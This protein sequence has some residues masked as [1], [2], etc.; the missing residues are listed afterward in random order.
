MFCCRGVVRRWCVA[1]FLLF[2]PLPLHGRHVDS[3]SSRT[4]RSVSHAQ[5]MHDK[6]RTLQDFKRRLWL[7][8]LL[9]EIHTAQIRDLPSGG[10]ASS[11]SGAILSPS[12]S[13]SS[14]SKP[15]GGSKH[16][17]LSFSPEEKE[18]ELHQET[19]KEQAYRGG[20]KKKRGRGGRRKE[21]EKKKRRA[22]SP[23]ML[24]EEEGSTL[25]RL[26]GVVL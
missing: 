8:E 13:G 1:V 9:D 16:L 20:R 12:T 26:Q 3:I 11:S 17:P 25:L 2:S 15:V 21:G 19:Q 14:H 23:H 6:G 4:R 24:K 10:G 18:E 22:R 7:Q 5:L